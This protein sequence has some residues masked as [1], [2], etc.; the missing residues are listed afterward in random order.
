MELMGEEEF[1][2]LTELCRIS[3]TEEEKQ[4]FLSSIRQI[5]VYVDQLKEVDVAG[6]PPCNTVLETLSNVFREDIPQQPLSR[7]AFLANAPAHV[8]GMI[9]VPPVIKSAEEF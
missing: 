7:E 6:V 4:N 2:K 3:C 5:L 1:K 9:R 8:G